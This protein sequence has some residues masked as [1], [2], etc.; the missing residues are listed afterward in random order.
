MMRQ[1]EGLIA[2]DELCLGIVTMSETPTLGNN[3]KPTLD[4][5]F[6]RLT[7]RIEQRMRWTSIRHRIRDNLFEKLGLGYFTLLLALFGMKTKSLPG[8]NTIIY[9]INEASLGVSFF[10]MIIFFIVWYL[11]QLIFFL[12]T[13]REIVDFPNQESFVKASSDLYFE[14]SDDQIQNA[15]LQ[16]R[17]RDKKHVVARLV[18]TFLQLVGLFSFLM[19]SLLLLASLFSL[20]LTSFPH[21]AI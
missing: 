19:A 11:T 10:L 16:W 18:C 2:R 3:E 12:A 6:K 13:P 4:D 17:Q 8:E 20:A 5:W 15:I 21:L 14:K 7:K 9:Q 1:S